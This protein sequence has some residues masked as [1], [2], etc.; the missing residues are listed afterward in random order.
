M[1]FKCS[2]ERKS[3]TSLTLNQKLEMIKLSEEGMSKAEIGP[4]L[5]LL[6]QTVSQ[7]VNAKEKF[8][9]EIKSATPVNTVIRKQNILTADMEKVLV[10]WVEDQ[11]SHNIPL[12]QNLIQSKALTLFNSLDWFMKFK[13]RSHLHNVKVE[14]EAASA[15]TE[16][17]AS[18][19]DLVRMIKVS[20]YTT[21]RI[22][23]VDETALYWKKMPSRTFIARE[24]KL[25]L[26]F[27]AQMTGSS[28]VS[29]EYTK[30]TLPV[31]YKWNHE[32]WMT[33]YLFTT[34][35]TEN[36]RPTGET[37]CSE[38]RFFSKHLLLIDNS[39]GQPRALMEMYNEIIHIW[40]KFTKNLWKGFTILDAIKNNHESWKELIP[41]L[42]DDYEGFKTSLEEVTA[43]VVEIVREV[44]LEV[45]PEDL[46]LTDE[47]R[48]WFLET[49]SPGE[50]AVK[51]V[52][53]TTKDLEYYINL[54]HKAAAE[55][56]RIDSNFERSSIVGKMVSNNFA[57]YR[58]IVH[59][60]KSQLMWQT[61]FLSY[62]K[63]LPH[64]PQPSATTDLI[65]SSHQ[66]PG[67][68]LL[69][70]KDYN[71]P[72]AQMMVDIF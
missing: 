66:Y 37:Y 27:K 14:G 10:F 57:F 30:S 31:L 54:I 12:S 5:D 45:G 50:C 56:E 41:T 21:Q 72:K 63:K 29:D 9:Q 6:C 15:K 13:E 53:M 3:H 59:E 65:S 25:R 52:E 69:Q 35:F 58:E 47:Q 67:K 51:F 36:F 16:A 11:T 38:E 32:T 64:Q 40:V 22:F 28:I 62:F 61:P 23:S 4:K 7:V 17:T 33:A 46:L 24:E 34:W 2:S 71:S 39:P 19:P 1:T 42:V 70:Q 68:T 18:Y 26:G 43:D 48:T 55:F 20:G 44:E 49:E 60:R 8:L